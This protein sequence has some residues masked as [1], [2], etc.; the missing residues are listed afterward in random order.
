[1]CR[2][3]K[4]LG[5]GRGKNFT[6]DMDTFS[7]GSDLSSAVK[8]TETTISVSWMGGGQIKECK[9]LL[10][11]LPP[12]VSHSNLLDIRTDLSSTRRLELR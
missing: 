7:T 4:S 1:M 9:C 2:V 5:G 3:K 12:Q 8:D 6:L 10:A 11:S